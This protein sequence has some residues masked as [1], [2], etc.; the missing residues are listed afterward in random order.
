VKPLLVA[1]DVVQV[2]EPGFRLTLIVWLPTALANEVNKALIAVA[3]M[4]Q[5]SIVKPLVIPVRIK[6]SIDTIE[7]NAFVAFVM[8]A[9]FEIIK[10]LHFLALFPNPFILVQVDEIVILTTDS[11]FTQFA[12]IETKLEANGKFIFPI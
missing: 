11:R 5:S 1:M 3:D 7:K 9:Q 8:P 4:L 6:V 10:P 12:N 2:A